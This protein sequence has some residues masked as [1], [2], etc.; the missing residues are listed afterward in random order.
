MGRRQVAGNRQNVN[1]FSNYWCGLWLPSNFELGRL[2]KRVTIIG[3]ACG[4]MGCTG[5]GHVIWVVELG[6]GGGR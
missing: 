4:S 1:D 3:V 6:G 5:L 2:P